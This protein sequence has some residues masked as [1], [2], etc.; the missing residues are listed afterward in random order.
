MHQNLLGFTYIETFGD[1]ENKLLGA[2]SINYFKP[3]GTNIYRL[4]EDVTVDTTASHYNLILAMKTK[5]DSVRMMRDYCDT[6]LLAYVPDTMAAGVSF[7]K[8]GILS[9]LNNQVGKGVIAPFQDAN[10]NARSPM[11]SD[12]QVIQ[13]ADDTTLYHFRYLIWTRSPV[14]RLFGTYSVN[15]ASLTGTL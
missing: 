1:T 12:V 6:S 4:E 3:N 8:A 2:A 13:D 5:H 9:E 15:E 10:G 7:V 11:P 14:K